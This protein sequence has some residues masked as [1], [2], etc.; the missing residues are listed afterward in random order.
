MAGLAPGDGT[1]SFQ[2]HPIVTS[3]AFGAGSIMF[4]LLPLAPGR[5]VRRACPPGHPSVGLR[6]PWPRRA[7]GLALLVSGAWAHSVPEAPVLGRFHLDWRVQGDEAARPQ[8]V[9][10]DGAGTVWFQWPAGEP[11]PAVFEGE[12]HALV[13]AERQPGYLVAHSRSRLFTLVLGPARARVE[14]PDGAEVTGADGALPAAVPGAPLGSVEP[15]GPLPHTTG[16]DE[17][18][19]VPVDAAASVAGVAGAPEG[20]PTSGSMPGRSPD[21][22]P[23]HSM[24]AASPPS[25]VPAA[26]WQALAHVLDAS[27]PREQPVLFAP[28][29]AR[30][31]EDAVATLGRLVSRLGAE[32]SVVIEGAG[33]GPAALALGL[34]RAQV[35]QAALVGR[36]LAPSRVQVRAQGHEAEPAGPDG[37]WRLGAVVRWRQG[38]D[39]AWGLGSAASASPS[40]SGP[41]GPAVVGEVLNTMPALS[42]AGAAAV[43]ADW[44]QVSRLGAVGPAHFEL[45]AQDGEI[46]VAL[47][48]WGQ[49]AGVDVR[50]ESPWSVPV[51]GLGPVD[52]PDFLDAVRQ[53]TRDARAQGWP[54]R[55]QAYADRVLRVSGGQ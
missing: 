18:P 30:L 48:R 52:A 26:R 6:G 47:R 17:R 2:N 40:A 16:P 45:R 13:Y 21:A 27:G 46:A 7:L 3:T 4:Q 36:G 10:D 55:V 23:F 38:P 14:R 34:A 32:G 29:Q 15:G 12:G 8:Q 41:A 5:L 24:I 11:A 44:A 31:S 39:P 1:G 43:A 50:W 22:S 51:A 53:V 54:L 37:R 49:A 20:V 35:L 33:D 28:G 19:A 9:F 42:V 25:P